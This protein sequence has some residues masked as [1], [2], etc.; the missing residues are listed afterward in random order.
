MRVETPASGRG[1]Q[2]QPRLSFTEISLPASF[3]KSFWLFLSTISLSRSFSSIILRLVMSMDTPNRR[4]GS[5]L[6]LK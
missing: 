2:N 4:S 3:C 5:P 1:A 6:G